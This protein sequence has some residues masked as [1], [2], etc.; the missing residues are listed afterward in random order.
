MPGGCYSQMEGPDDL[1]RREKPTPE[2][3][4][5][6]AT[7]TGFFGSSLIKLVGVLF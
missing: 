7:F 1:I 5:P 6:A 4:Q 3:V 2:A